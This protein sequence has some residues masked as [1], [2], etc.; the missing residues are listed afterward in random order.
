MRVENDHSKAD[1]K[2]AQQ[3]FCLT[4]L[5]VMALIG[6]ALLASTILWLCILAVL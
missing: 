5:S 3:G 1:L 4:S 6:Y 2:S